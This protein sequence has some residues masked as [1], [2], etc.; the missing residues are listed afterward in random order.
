MEVSGVPKAQ[1][2]SDFRYIPVGMR[3]QG[4]GFIC[5]LFG[6]GEKKDI[7]IWYIERQGSKWSE[8]INAGPA[9][10]SPKNEYYISF[11]GQGKMY[12]S[13]NKGTAPEQDKNY[14]V[15]SAQFAK[16]AFQ[17][18]QKLG[19]A[20][21]SEH[22]EADVFVAPDE[23]YLIYCA[24]RPDGQGQGDLWI[25]F[26][27]GQ[28]AWLPAKNMGSVINTP[29]YEFCPFV[30]ADGR[31]LFFSR[32]GDIYWLSAQVIQDLKQSGK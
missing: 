22:Y 27:D 7:D 24:E 6:Q 1:Y 16:G 21:N 8:P 17:P 26:Q 19:A 3:Q 18:A 20:V 29:G 11:T 28:G 31:Y 14:D 23:R 2:I 5:P 30:S 15:Y 9:I 13:S 25:S 32:D 12:F 4:F 10:N